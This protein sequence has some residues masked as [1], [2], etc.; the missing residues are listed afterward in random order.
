MAYN[1]KK[2][3]KL[4]QCKVCGRNE[5][6]THSNYNVWDDETIENHCF[7]CGIYYI[8]EAYY[9][10]DCEPDPLLKDSALGSTFLSLIERFGGDT[11]FFTL[12]QMGIG[13]EILDPETNVVARGLIRPLGN[14]A[15]Q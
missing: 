6:D 4:K 9:I 14:G 13:Y 12:G 3:K 8:D 11:G 15:V 10:D 7:A 1:M 5:L 2:Q